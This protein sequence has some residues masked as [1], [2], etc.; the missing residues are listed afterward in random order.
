MVRADCDIIPTVTHS[1]C[2]IISNGFFALHS[3][4]IIFSFL[5]KMSTLKGVELG[6]QRIAHWIISFM[7]KVSVITFPTN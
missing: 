6:I 7:R 2:K 5:I 3:S 4:E 1:K